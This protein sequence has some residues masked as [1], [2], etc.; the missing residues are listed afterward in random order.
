MIPRVQ[1]VAFRDPSQAS[2][3]AKT[4]AGKSRFIGG[5]TDIVVQM[6]SGKTK[7]TYL[8]DVSDAPGLRGIDEIYGNIR[9]GAFTT[10]EEIRRSPSVGRHLP[11]LKEAADVFAAWQVRNLAT[12]GGNLCNASPAA[13]SAP[14][15]LVY[16]AEVLAMRG[17]K[18]LQIP[19]G[20]FFKGPGQTALQD[21]DLV[22]GVRIPKGE[23]GSAFL[24]LGRR[25]ASILAVVSA[26]ARIQLS[27]EKVGTVRVA[28]GSVAPT[29]VRALHVEA[30]LFGRKPTEE[31]LSAASTLVLKDIKPISD[32]R[33][34]AQYREKMAV[35]LTAKVLRTALMRAG[36]VQS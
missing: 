28:L 17:D 4:Q 18:E 6:R 19:I 33:A 12:L 11:A 35:V 5:G 29:P 31:N 27:G 26:A 16:D 9:I 36:G 2:H 7:A 22:T 24:K 32:I 8:V 10:M 14:P 21:G 34:S 1:Y 25:R 15:L 13:D 20:L 30:Y 23:G 3:F